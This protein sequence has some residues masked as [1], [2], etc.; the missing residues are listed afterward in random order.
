M[1]FRSKILATAAQVA[2][3]N[4]VIRQVTASQHGG[5][6]YDC[7]AINSQGSFGSSVMLLVAPAFTQQPVSQGDLEVGDNV[8]LTCIAESHPPPVYQWEQFNET[9]QS[10]MAL[11]GETSTTLQLTSLSVSDFGM[12][13]C[14]VTVAEFNIMVILSNTAV[15][16]SKINASHMK[17]H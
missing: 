9:S 16:S 17:Y 1:S 15:I 3:L 10:F 14:K 5:N 8:T 7:V 2:S 11:T 4:F 12:Y 13:R 6:V